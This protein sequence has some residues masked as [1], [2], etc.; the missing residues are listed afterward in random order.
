MLN[1]KPSGCL[2]VVG[3]ILNSVRS[4]ARRCDGHTWLWKGTQS[5]AMLPALFPSLQDKTEAH[6]YSCLG[7]F[8][9]SSREAV[10][11]EDTKVAALQQELIEMKSALL[12]A[13][14]AAVSSG[15]PHL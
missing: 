8:Q 14:S 10:D 1:I 3:V 6:R 7:M 12:A 15:C 5:F 4:S 11:V 9:V 2:C 13:E